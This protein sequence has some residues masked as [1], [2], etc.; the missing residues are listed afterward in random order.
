MASQKG[1]VTFAFSVAAIDTADIDL[2]TVEAAK[3]APPL[4]LD[5]RKTARAKLPPSSLRRWSKSCLSPLFRSS[6]NAL[7][8]QVGGECAGGRV[9]RFA[10]GG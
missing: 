2:G 3:N 10:L 7:A 9:C 8:E 4:L 1:T 5:W 6:S